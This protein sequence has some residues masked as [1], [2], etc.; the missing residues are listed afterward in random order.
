MLTTCRIPSS[1]STSRST[2]PPIRMKM[3]PTSSNGIT[4]Q[5]SS[6]HSPWHTWETTSPIRQM[7]SQKVENPPN[8]TSFIPPRKESS[9]ASDTSSRT[10][11]SKSLPQNT[12]RTPSKRL[13][14]TSTDS[15]STAVVKTDSSSNGGHSH[16]K[17]N[18]D[19][20]S[21]DSSCMVCTA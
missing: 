9:S 17:I 18:R 14:I 5:N 6:G 3:S 12:S 11:S 16:Y 15:S 20:I 2:L 4:S 13:S 19:C 10:I 21:G 7:T 1:N 8:T